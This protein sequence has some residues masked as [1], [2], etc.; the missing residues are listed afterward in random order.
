[1]LHSPCYNSTT[2]SLLQLRSPCCYTLATLSCHYALATLSLLQLRHTLATPSACYNSALLATTPLLPSPCYDS[3][4]LATTLLLCSA[5]YD[6]ALP[7]TTL[8]LP[9]PCP[10]SCHPLL[11]TTPLSLLLRSCYPHLATTPL[12][13]LLTLLLPSP[14]YDSAP[15]SRNA[16]LVP[17]HTPLPLRLALRLPYSRILNWHTSRTRASPK[18]KGR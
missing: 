17:L 10:R 8:W 16:L 14:C 7:A 5:C 1:M 2:L 15:L 6:S 4:L 12:S 3:A 11:A 18:V 13:L 9:S